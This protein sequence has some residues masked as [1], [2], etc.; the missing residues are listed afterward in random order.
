MLNFEKEAF[1]FWKK[2]KLFCKKTN[3]EEIIIN[4]INFS[5]NK[6]QKILIKFFLILFFLMK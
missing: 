6:K 2:N 1:F 5:N 4:K 3:V